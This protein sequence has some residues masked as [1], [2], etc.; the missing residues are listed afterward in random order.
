M[1]GIYLFAFADLEIAL[2]GIGGI[3]LGGVLMA[4]ILHSLAAKKENLRKS[5][6][7]TAQQTIRGKTE[8]LQLLTGNVKEKEEKL[9]SSLN[10]I[11]EQE[12]II[13][14]KR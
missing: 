4:W 2:S 12:N 7:E 14:K 13:A 5:E 11:K 9:Q 8:E 3:V 1:F 10:K 6:I